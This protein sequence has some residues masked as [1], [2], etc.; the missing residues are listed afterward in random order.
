MSHTEIPR[1]L[2]MTNDSLPVSLS[3]GER[4]ELPLILSLPKGERDNR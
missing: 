4:S 2:G 3:K 1:R